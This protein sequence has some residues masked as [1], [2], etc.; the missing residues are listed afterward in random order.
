MQLARRQSIDAASQMQIGLSPRSA[1]NWVV[2]DSL[3]RNAEETFDSA[4]RIRDLHAALLAHQAQLLEISLELQVHLEAQQA[5]ASPSAGFGGAPVPAFSAEASQDVVAAANRRDDA[6]RMAA[7]EA[8]QQAYAAR[9]KQGE[10]KER[11]FDAVRSQRRQLGDTGVG[12]AKKA[13]E[14]HTVDLQLG[15]GEPAWKPLGNLSD[16]ASL[17]PTE[18]SRTKQ[19]DQAR[20]A[21]EA[22]LQE[23]AE[24][25]PLSV[26]EGVA[27]LS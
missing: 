16:T 14:D 9:A 2:V 22:R 11:L 25:A 3:H 23:A 19:L 15:G 4:L 27:E 26:T 5:A 24:A 7:A 10:R 6:A 13:V 8:L 1:A 17:F 18:P 21:L 20:A 12:K